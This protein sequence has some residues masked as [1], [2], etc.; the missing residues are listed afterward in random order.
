MAS[1]SLGMKLQ[2]LSLGMASHFSAH[3]LTQKFGLA[4]PAEELVYIATKKGFQ[5]I[6]KGLT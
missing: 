4:K 5:L 3:P 1:F 6:Q 2:G